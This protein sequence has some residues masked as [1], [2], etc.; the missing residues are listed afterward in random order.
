M[1]LC[2]VLKWLACALLAC[3]VGCVS[4]NGSQLS[5]ERPDSSAP[6]GLQ[7]RADL[8]LQLGQPLGALY[9]G[10]LSTQPQR[11]GRGPL[12]SVV[13]L[14]T[15]TTLPWTTYKPT[16]VVTSVRSRDWDPNCPEWRKPARQQK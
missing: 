12:E 14:I 1:K 2:G 11:A 5:V 10:Q 15:E 4:R 7:E 9:Q 3:T 13:D 6:S 8:E 16:C